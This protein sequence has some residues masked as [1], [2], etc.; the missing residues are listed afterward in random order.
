MDDKEPRDD[1][2]GNPWHP[3]LRVLRRRAAN[4][5]PERRSLPIQTPG[6]DPPPT[7]DDLFRPDP[8]GG[9]LVPA[10]DLTEPEIRALADWL[11][12]EGEEH[13]A[14]LELGAAFLAQRDSLR[15]LREEPWLPEDEEPTPPGGPAAP[16]Q[17]P[18]AEE[19]VSGMETASTASDCLRLLCR[20]RK[21]DLELLTG[22][23][24]RLVPDLDSRVVLL[25]LCG[26]LPVMDQQVLEAALTILNAPPAVAAQARALNGGK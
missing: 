9:R 17:R 15:Q 24:A 11:G 12:L 6:A 14:F 2:V 20:S 10:R 22:A 7:W 3:F 16:A 13:A 21:T 1:F 5:P 23:V 26:T 18:P 25:Q 4:L 19:T 8:A